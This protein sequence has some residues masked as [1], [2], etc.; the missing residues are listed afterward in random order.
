MMGYENACGEACVWCSKGIERIPAADGRLHHPPSTSG[1]MRT[2]TSPTREQYE[3]ELESRILNL[4]NAIDRVRAAL[5]CRNC[6]DNTC[7]HCKTPVRIR[8]RNVVDFAVVDDGFA[9]ELASLDSLVA[10]IRLYIAAQV[11]G[12][13]QAAWRALCD[14]FGVYRETIAE[15][16]GIHRSYLSKSVQNPGPDMR[17]RIERELRRVAIGIVAAATEPDSGQRTP[18]AEPG[19]TQATP[20]GSAAQAAPGG[21][22][23]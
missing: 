4:Q 10:G 7:M 14:V 18:A 12:D 13:D 15:G 21:E 20:G 6:S 9:A 5:L 17:T 22:Q 19:D 16:A 23:L 1:A 8:V 3:K 11:A 2:C